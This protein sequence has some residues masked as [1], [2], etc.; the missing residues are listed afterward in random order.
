MTTVDHTRS[1]KWGE[2]LL[3]GGRCSVLEGHNACGSHF[4]TQ[5]TQ[6]CLGLCHTSILGHDIIDL[7]EGEK[8]NEWLKY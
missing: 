4:A 5:F 8:G 1:R 6:E 2:K 3:E 7:E